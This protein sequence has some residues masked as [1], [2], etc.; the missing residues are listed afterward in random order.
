VHLQ[1]KISIRR[2]A[3]PQQNFAAGGGLSFLATQNHVFQ[4]SRLA[5]SGEVLLDF[6]SYITFSSIF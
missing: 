1:Y 5:L 6:F 4:V 2:S 3:L